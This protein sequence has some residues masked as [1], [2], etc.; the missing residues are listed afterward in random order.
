MTT[1]FSGRGNLAEAPTFKTV[2]V[3]GEHREVAQMRIY[4]DRPVPA[5][6]DAFQDKGGFW[7]D[8]NCWGWRAQHVARILSKGARVHVEGTLVQENW[9][10]REAGEDRSK[11]RLN[12]DYIALDLS[13]IET[14]TLRPKS[15]QGMVA[16]EQRE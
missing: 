1:R 3:S 11:L 12:A 4:F 5:D 2:D 16:E 6:D 7:L 9:T 8:V 13:R 14:V 10:D 15:P